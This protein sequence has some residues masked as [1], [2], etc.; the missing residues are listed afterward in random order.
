MH[1]YTYVIYVDN[2][3]FVENLDAENVW[4]REFHLKYIKIF[5]IKPHFA[6][7]I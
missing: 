6:L 2:L 5:V 1:I 3:Y 4:S 7:D